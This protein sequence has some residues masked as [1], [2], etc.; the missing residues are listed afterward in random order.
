VTT[1]ISTTAS[2]D[3]LL[4][5]PVSDTATLSGTATQPADPVI[6][7]TGTPGPAAAG[8]I[9]FTLYGPN[10]CATL[11]YTSAGVTVSGDGTYTT[12]APQ[13]VPTA[14]GTYHWVASYGGSS[15]NTAGTTHNADCQ[16]SQ[17]SVVVS[18]VRSSLS[19]A[20]TWVPN[21]SVTVS[22]PAG[23]ALAGTVS[24]SLHA[25]DDC[26]GA[27][28]YSTTAALSGASPATVSTSNTS[29]QSASGSFS[30]LVS[31]D[32]TNPAQLDIPPSCHETSALTISNGG[33]ITSR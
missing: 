22:A 1:A 11:V 20:Q 4:G 9:V 10:D 5:Q 19:S 17:E 18:A 27:S 32:S 25:T 3:V 30:W 8:S 7:L 2:D 13:F 12:P 14:P 24:F 26:E 29:A 33:T 21:D 23:G 15:P 28:I 6:N 16:E 31:Y